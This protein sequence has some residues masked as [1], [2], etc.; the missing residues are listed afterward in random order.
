LRQ[1]LELSVQNAAR[2]ILH[3]IALITIAFVQAIP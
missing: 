1:Q 3:A 2:L